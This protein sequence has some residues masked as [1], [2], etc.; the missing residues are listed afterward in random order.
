MGLQGKPLTAY[1]ALV[2]RR[3]DALQDA[4]DATKGDMSEYGAVPLKRVPK[5][6]DADHPHEALLRRKSLIVTLDI[7][8]ALKPKKAEPLEVA[9]KAFE[10]FTP[11]HE[12]LNHNPV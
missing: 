4:I 7:G 11:L 2:D 10:R 9:T 5:P 6:Y 1:R 8:K 12:F 3:G